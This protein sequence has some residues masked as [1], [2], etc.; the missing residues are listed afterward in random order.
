MEMDNETKGKVTELQM[1]EQ[2]LQNFMMQKQ[3][4]Q[5]S[6]FEIENALNELNK[7]PKGAY[8]LVG[9]VM[10]N[11]EVEKLKKELE[12]KKEVL[13]VRVEGIEKKE[14]EMAEKAEKLQK[15]VMESLQGKND[16]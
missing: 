11:S 15:E 10:V 9:S 4:F 13:T 14:K 3:N 6:L 8:K 7:N 5:T 16:K 2:S 12:S 1:L